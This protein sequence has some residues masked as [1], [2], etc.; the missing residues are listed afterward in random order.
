M[1]EKAFKRSVGPMYGSLMVC[2]LAAAGPAFAEDASTQASPDNATSLGT[3]TVSASLNQTLAEDMPLHTTV[4]TQDDIK[5]STSQ[6]L[7]QLLRTVPG[8]NF[9]GVPAA[10]SDPTGQQTKMRGLGN[11]KVLVLLDGI[12]IIDPFYLT[13]QFHKVALADVDHIEVIRGGTSS[14]WGNMAVAGMVN[15][16]TKRPSDNTGVVTVGAGNHGT[17]SL[18]WSQNFK[19]SDALALNLAVNQ[20]RT[21]GY[22]T[23]PSPYRWKF[24][25]QRANSARDTNIELSAYFRLTHSLNGF[26][27]L[28]NHEQDQHIGYSYGRN[29]QKNPDGALGL[30]QRFD[31]DSSLSLRAWAQNVHFTKYNG[32][33]CYYQLAG[34]CL[35]SNAKDQVV[36]NDVV[37]YYSQYGDLHYRERGSSLTYSRFF[38]AFFNSLQVG[39][40]YRHLSAKDSES[41]FAT[42]G[43]PEIPQVLNATGYGRGEQTFGGAFVQAK[44][45]PLDV[46]Q[47]TFSGRYDSWRNTDQVH[48]LTKASTG[49]V[50]GGTLPSSSK[51]AF[52]PGLGLHYDAT[53]TWS[54][55]GATYKAFRAPGFNNT[56]RSYGVGP[57][58]VANPDLGPETMTGWE[59]GSDYRNDAVSLGATYF[60]Y[61]IKDMIATYRITSAMGAPQPVLSL[62]S[63]SAAAPNLTNCGGSANYYTNDQNGESHGVELD[64]SWRIAPSLKLGAYF[65]YT[66][67]Y[68][69]SE[70]SSI[71]TPLHVQLV[72]IPEKTGSLDA[73]WNPTDRITMYGQMFYAGPMYLDET[74]THGTNYGQGGNVI[75]NASASYALNDNLDL[76]AS[77]TN[78]FGKKYSE[79]AYAVT[80]PWS[81]TLSMPRTFFVSATV[82]Y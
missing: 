43:S 59:V 5:N 60:R 31:K 37:E 53:D 49:V 9:T 75:Y 40:D 24:P 79:N 64:G 17:A 6:T 65:T 2:A 55:R 14:L 77:M 19:V 73:T 32:A 13:T 51:S 28:G 50:S 54:F 22:I 39:I 57:T 11:A 3:V 68:L 30:D 26:L 80:Q 46:L 25:R 48:T 34:G 63:S 45:S 61:R 15:I 36:S 12:P 1:K 41:F 67:T 4:I 76:S 44:V 18:S 33:T 56:T 66:H 23:T 38:N 7:D 71:T 16:V 58:T 42:P 8:F 20:Y 69:T 47:L 21:D 78:I 62:C 35:N 72:G 29:L 70:A 52:N 82:K 10:I 27:R 74:T 81:R